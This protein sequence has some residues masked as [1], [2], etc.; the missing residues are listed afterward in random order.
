MRFTIEAELPLG[1][2]QG[3]AP[4]GRPE[5]MPSLVRLHAALLCAAGFGPRAVPDGDGL[6]PCDAD[7]TALRWLEEHPPDGAVI[8]QI[9]VTGVSGIAYRD[10]GTLFKRPGKALRVKK[11]PKPPGTSVAVAGRFVWS[12]R[13]EPPREVQQA[14]GALCG[15][16]PYLGTTES[17]VRLTAAAGDQPEPTHHLVRDA[18]LFT[19]GGTDISVCRP[20]RTAELMAA[21]ARRS[22]MPPEPRA[23]YGTDEESTSDEPPREAVEPMRYMPREEPVADVPWAQAILVP[24]SEAV[25]PPH[26]VRWAIAVHR[27]LIK[28]I[29]EGAPPLITGVYPPGQ[30]RPANRLAVHLL[31]A[32]APVVGGVKSAGL[33]II[34]VPPQTVTT[35]VEVLARAVD[36]LRSVRGPRG[37]V[38]RF[39][40]P[41][42]V[43][44]GHR[45][46]APPDPGRLRLWRTEPA[47][48]PDI[49]GVRTAEW[50]FS[51]A[52]LLSVGFVWKQ[53]L[54]TVP[55]RGDAGYVRLARAV[56]QA[57]AAVV[58]A[59]PLRTTDVGAY[60]HRV[61]TDAVVRPYTALL[62]LGNLAGAQTV[63]AIGQSRHLGGG[64]LV[65]YD[66]ACGT[67]RP[68]DADAEV[69]P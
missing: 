29:G 11:F 40:G 54:P 67:P 7:E 53:H 49:R 38:I 48:V 37:R 66:V 26:R 51:H 55:G 62:W 52:A 44:A 13:E 6:R 20:G 57:G 12:W 56:T 60:A 33:L 25:P 22:A 63:A 59:W 39:V 21:H 4:D 8:P 68:I 58:R 31:D 9:T 16:V 47:A 30:P 45:F 34:L 32:S 19:P 28:W 5:P 36:G 46:W 43:V 10:D 61:N 24:L 3:A 17:P 65:P 50:T 27:A 15:D 23:A 41:A 42:R 2:Y 69:R 1:T 64:L 14:L 18:G 35:D